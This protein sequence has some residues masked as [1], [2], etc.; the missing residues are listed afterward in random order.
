MPSRRFEEQKWLLD[1]VIETIGLDWDQLRR[2]NTLNVAGLDAGSDYDWISGAVTRFDEMSPAFAT[3]A[4]RRRARA[5]AAEKD[6]NLVTARESYFIAAVFYGWA[7]WPLHDRPE[8]NAELNALKIE[9]YG[10]YAALAQ[11]RVE[12]ADI[13]FGDHVVPGWLH[14]PQGVEGPHPVVVM[15]PGMD[16]FKELQVA[17]YGDK[18]LERGFAVLTIDGPGH[19]EAVVNGL[20]ITPGNFG[21]AGSAVLDWIEQHDDLDS[22]RVG[23]YGRSF[24]SYAAAVF[25]SA[26]ADRL[27]GVAVALVIHEPGLRT[28]M[29]G[30]SP[31]FKARFMFMAGYDDEAEFD[32]FVQGF[33][34]APRAASI[35]C[36]LLILAGEIDQ[37]SPVEHSY[38]LA[39]QVG[40][41]VDM[42]V[43][44]AERHAIGRSEAA[45]AGPH[46]YVTAADWLR[47]RVIEGDAPTGRRLTF[48]TRSGVVEDRS[49]ELAP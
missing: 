44:E 8:R 12:R 34:L 9:C 45:K 36:P 40:G 39:R 20:H 24:G 47:A 37:L 30:S 33:D 43:Y 48:V 17:M 22:D 28:L 42:V 25:A 21:D 31:S 7:Q 32:E 41:P 1:T 13:P 6:G 3:A 23:V 49:A 35:T 29:D 46:W 10:R 27:R 16:T 26:N 11:R 5:Q 15:V 14:L 38:R 18:F 19:S 2:V 4:G